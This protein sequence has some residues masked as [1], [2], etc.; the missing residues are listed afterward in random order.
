[1]LYGIWGKKGETVRTENRLMVAWGWRG[2]LTTK[3]AWRCHGMGV[4]MELF[5]IFIEVAVARLYA[6]VKTCRPVY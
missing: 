4:G 1:M 3:S 2:R 5:F 6:C